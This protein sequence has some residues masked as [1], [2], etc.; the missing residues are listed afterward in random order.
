MLSGRYDFTFP[1]ETSKLHMFRLMGTPEKDKKHVVFDTAHDVTIKR[2]QF[3]KE[4]LD[5]LDKYLGTVR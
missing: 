1:L 3:V 5:W 2:S 4:V